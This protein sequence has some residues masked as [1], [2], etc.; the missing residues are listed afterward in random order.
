MN[1]AGDAVD[2]SSAECIT[3]GDDLIP[4]KE[5]VGFKTLDYYTTHLDSPFEPFGNTNNIFSSSQSYA[6]TTANESSTPK[7]TS[8]SARKRKRQANNGVDGVFLETLNTFVHSQNDRLGD[9]AKRINVDYD[10][11]KLRT[12]V[13]QALDV[14]PQIAKQ[15]KIWVAQQL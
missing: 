5:N 15:E 9:I 4:S 10:I 13:Y 3:F 1:D 11:K 2:D 6:T 12:K 8:F 7:K 14:I